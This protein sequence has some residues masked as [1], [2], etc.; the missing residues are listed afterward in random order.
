MDATARIAELSGGVADPSAGTST[1]SID[2]HADQLRERDYYRRAV[3][4]WLPGFLRYSLDGP[5][6][7]PRP[8]PGFPRSPASGCSGHS[9]SR[10]RQAASV[11]RSQSTARGVS[12]RTYALGMRSIT[13]DEGSADAPG[14]P[15]DDVMSTG[16]H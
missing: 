16:G 15:H 3:E 4:L 10:G 8:T 12:P 11:S 1:P 7:P 14:S 6:S 2:E 9:G 13:R 5:S